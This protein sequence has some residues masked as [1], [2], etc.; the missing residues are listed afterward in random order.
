MPLD[1]MVLVLVCVVAAAGVTIWIGGL[2]AAAWQ[3]PA[4]GW[5]AAIPAALVGYV[6][7]RVIADRLSN[8]EDDHYDKIEK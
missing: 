2:V 1:K 4:V 7:W 8:S 6:I 3:V 5:L